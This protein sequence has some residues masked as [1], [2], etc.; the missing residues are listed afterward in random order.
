MKCVMGF[1]VLHSRIESFVPLVIVY[2]FST[3]F[4]SV[5]SKLLAANFHKCISFSY[6]VCSSCCEHDNL[7]IERSDSLVFYFIE[8]DF[9]DTLFSLIL[10]NMK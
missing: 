9:I 1:M 10:I 6:F 5:E 8:F 7:K 2:I 4:R 3:F